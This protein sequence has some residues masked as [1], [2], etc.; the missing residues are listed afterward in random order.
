MKTKASIFA[1]FICIALASLCY[2][3]GADDILGVWNNQEKDARIEVFKCGDK[4]CGKIVWLKEP[5][6]P[7]GSTEGTPGTPRLDNHNPDPVQRT[8][9]IFGLQIVK[10]FVFDG[11]SVWKGG[12]VYDP[13][14][15]KTYSGKMTLVSPDVL[16]LRGFIGISLFGRNATWTRQLRNAE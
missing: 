15:G 9:P 2:A 16:K 3:A 1:A 13:K 10:D 7:A 5:N 6:Y 8:R 11:D 12:T 4:Y 14:V